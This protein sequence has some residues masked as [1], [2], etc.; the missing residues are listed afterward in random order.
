MIDRAILHDADVTVLQGGDG[1]MDV[2]PRCQGR[3]FEAEKQIA[4]PGSYHRQSGLRGIFQNIL[5]RKKFDRKQQYQ[6]SPIR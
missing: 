6:E 2:C 5:K 4:K 1:E 3:V